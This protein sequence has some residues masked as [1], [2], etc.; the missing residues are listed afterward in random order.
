MTKREVSLN[1]ETSDSRCTLS[2]GGMTCGACVS[3]VERALS[4]NGVSDASVSLMT[5]RAVVTFDPSVTSVT[6]LIDIVEAVGFDADHISTET[7]EDLRRARQKNAGSVMQHATLRVIGE[8][9]FLRN[10][11][12]ELLSTLPG[13]ASTKILPTYSKYSGNSRSNHSNEI[14]VNR[15]A[16]EAEIYIVVTYDDKELGVRDLTVQAQSL[17]RKKQGSRFF[18]RLSD[19]SLGDNVMESRREMEIAEWKRLLL[20]ALIFAV[21]AFCIAMIF[22]WFGLLETTLHKNIFVREEC[23]CGWKVQSVLLWILA[24][25]VQFYCAKRFYIS[26]WKGLQH[27][28]LGMSFM[29]VAGTSVAYFYSVFALVY[30]GTLEKSSDNHGSMDDMSNMSNDVS[31]NV[32]HD[33]ISHHAHF[34]ETSTTLIT[35]V[36]LGKYMESSAKRR[37]CMAMSKLAG[38]SASDAKV[39]VEGKEDEKKN[40]SLA[41]DVLQSIGI[42]VASKSLDDKSEED[43]EMKKSDTKAADTDSLTVRNI[44]AQ[45]VQRG[46]LLLIAP[47]SKIPADGVV[48]EG[49][50]SVDESLLTGEP[51]PVTKNPGDK[52]VGA[53]I[54]VDGTIKVRVTGVGQDTMLSRIIKLV[55]D[56]QSSKAPVQAFADRIAG[57]F[58]PTVSVISLLTF[59]IWIILTTQGVVP[60]SWYPSGTNDLVLSIVFSVSVMVIACPCALGLATPTAVLVGTGVGAENGVLIKG[61][62]AL[63]VAQGLTDIVFDKTGTLTRG[64]LDVTKACFLDEASMLLARRMQLEKSVQGALDK[65]DGKGERWGCVDP[66]TIARV[67]FYAGSAELYSEHP[68]GKAIVQRARSTKCVR[69]LVD[70]DE[71]TFKSI[72]GRGVA[73]KVEGIDVC[74]GNRAWMKEANV[75]ISSV[76]DLETAMTKIEDEGKTAIAVAID[77]SIVAVFSL[78]DSQKDEAAMTVTVLRR[79]GIKVWMLTGDNRRTARSVASKIG[80]DPRHVIAEVLPSE[81]SDHIAMLQE[82]G[83]KVAMVGD[84]VNDAPALAMADLGVAI[85]AGTDVAIDAADIVLV[86]SKLLDVLLAIDLSRTVFRRIRLNFLFALGYNVLGIPLAAGVFFP[87]IKVALP[88]EVAGGAMALSSVSVV[89]SS[90]LLNRYKP[91]QVIGKRYG[92]VSTDVKDSKAQLKNFTIKY[93]SKSDKRRGIDENELTGSCAEPLSVLGSVKELFPKE[94][95]VSYRIDSGCAMARGGECSCDPSLCKC[96]ACVA[97]GGCSNGKKQKKSV[98]SKSSSGRLN[99]VVEAKYDE[100][101]SD[102]IEMD[103]ISSSSLL[104]EYFS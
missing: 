8:G 14:R 73:C 18:V 69:T 38:L 35:F 36:I 49:I 83:G 95:I 78:E 82:K 26:A 53:T 81:K 44:P 5:E 40:S 19:S 51:V 72:P 13:V 55:N 92:K 61:G 89:L 34:F 79:M 29:I 63:E 21:P 88:P 16:N 74:I 30:S 6:E 3:T 42:N 102:D 57:V 75:S 20:I 4:V 28:N 91:P 99:G 43:K 48:E 87:L 9:D 58:V 59:I 64:K 15:G 60:K 100:V 39:I 84:G 22:P 12:E 90:L 68:L 52:A 37:T 86:N 98:Q 31:H 101:K 103:E 47:G 76:E 62:H 67:L 1:V 97:A 10:K 17:G 33:G 32:D 54:N 104:W 94:D 41:I 96:S 11:F 77:G 66:K 23:N 65:L 27:R 50:S 80:I 46:D 85:G 93:W 24:T 70:P 2:V 45:M 56:A 71:G 7:A 25:P